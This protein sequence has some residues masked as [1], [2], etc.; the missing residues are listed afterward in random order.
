MRLAHQP[1]KRRE[2]VV[3]VKYIAPTVS[4]IENVIDIP[5]L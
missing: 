4:P 1:Y 3:F 2:I 5:T